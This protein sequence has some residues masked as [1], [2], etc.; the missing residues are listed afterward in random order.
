MIITSEMMYLEIQH[1]KALL[2]ELLERK[3]P[4]V[5]KELTMNQ[6]KRLLGKGKMAIV[7]EVKAGRLNASIKKRSVTK[8][9]KIKLYDYYKFKRSDLIEYQKNKFSAK[10][11][12]E[13]VELTTSFSPEDF[14]KGFH[15]KRKAS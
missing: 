1:L 2:L 14:I 7:D 12:T 15:K 6:A 10:P 13:F 9:G 8:N 4:E 11:T 5:E 3:S